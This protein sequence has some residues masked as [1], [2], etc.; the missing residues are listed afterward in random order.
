VKARSIH[1]RPH[2]PPSNSFLADLSAVRV[3]A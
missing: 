3:V 2:L 1:Y